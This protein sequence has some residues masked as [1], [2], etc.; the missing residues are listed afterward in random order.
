VGAEVSGVY[1]VK[2][3][4]FYLNDRA[5]Q[6][7]ARL[8]PEQDVATRF[9]REQAEA[10]RGK[11]LHGCGAGSFARIVRL[12]P[13]RKT[14][15]P[16][17][18]QCIE[19]AGHNVAAGK[20]LGD[21]PALFDEAMQVAAHRARAEE[22]EAVVAWLLGLADRAEVGNVKLYVCGRDVTAGQGPAIRNAAAFI[23]SGAHRSVK[24]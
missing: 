15:D 11:Y 8:T 16:M 14:F 13:K 7:H 17:P 12:V 22:R 23:R 1:L 19:Q 2:V 5:T 9:T 10:W 24:Q 21:S 18:A 6:D 3:F 4:R 20:L